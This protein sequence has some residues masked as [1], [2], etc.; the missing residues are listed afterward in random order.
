MIALI[1]LQY[2]VD[3]VKLYFKVIIYSKKSVIKGKTFMKK[4]GSMIFSLL[5]DYS[6]LHSSLYKEDF[7]NKRGF[8]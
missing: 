1:N 2:A 3:N 6:G 5:S 7:S 8:I 4:K